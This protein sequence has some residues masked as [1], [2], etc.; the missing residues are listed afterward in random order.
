[1]KMML[2]YMSLVAYKHVSPL[3]SIADTMH[4]LPKSLGQMISFFEISVSDVTGNI[5]NYQPNSY[6]EYSRGLVYC[7]L[8]RRATLSL[9]M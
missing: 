6:T 5:S 7:F 8:I 1:M 3:Q 2:P 4:A 9:M